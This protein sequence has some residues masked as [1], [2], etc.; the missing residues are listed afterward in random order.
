MQISIVTPSF[1]NSDWLK[2]C[3]ASVADQE[4]VE[5]EHIVQDSCSDDTTAQWLPG[6][7][8][9]RA[10]IEKDD[11][12]YDAI[13]R[14]LRRARGDILA[15]LN[16]DEQ[17]L[18]GALRAVADFFA[19]HPEAGIVL[20]DAIVVDANGQYI[21]HRKSLVPRRGEAWFRMRTIT[22]SIFFR[23]RVLEEHALFFDSRWKVLADFHWMHRALARG[24][25][26]A[27]LPLF[28]SIFTETG[29]NLGLSARGREE[30][31]TTQA[32]APRGLR[33]LSPL[34]VA[35]YRL[36]AWAAGLYAQPPF[37]YSIY[38]RQDPQ[39]RVTFHVD[40]PIGYWKG[41]A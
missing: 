38:T 16:S 30:S 6:D 2:L 1:R 33:L 34:L 32:M 29:E 40:R 31:H 17:Y 26:I 27:T 10:F 19:A 11:G 25:R 20:S 5:V 8:R 4:G 22:C 9:V 37:S 18:P 14:G 21:C 39:R 24:V 15:H 35:K 12:M 28:T 13:N 41:R 7:G 36:R 23:R 3:I